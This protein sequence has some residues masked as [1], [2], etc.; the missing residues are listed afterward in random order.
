MLK[1]ENRQISER[2]DESRNDEFRKR[3][4]DWLTLVEAR[5]DFIKFFR[6]RYTKI[7]SIHAAKIENVTEKFELAAGKFHPFI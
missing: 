2:S 3:R 7:L 1:W 5:R 6:A 4:A